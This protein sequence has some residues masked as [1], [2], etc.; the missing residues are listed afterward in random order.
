MV[1][2]E[3][4]NVSKIPFLLIYIGNFIWTYLPGEEIR[5]RCMGVSLL[6]VWSITH[7]VNE[8]SAAKKP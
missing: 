8:K 4:I 1:N 5:S 2:V 6:N 3:I 7:I